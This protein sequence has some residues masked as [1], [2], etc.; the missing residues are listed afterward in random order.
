MTSAAPFLRMLILIGEP[1]S[2]LPTRSTGEESP[3]YDVRTVSTVSFYEQAAGCGCP[4]SMCAG[5]GS[6]PSKAIPNIRVA[7][8]PQDEPRGSLHA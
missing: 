4:A 5:L 6:N 1:I 2:T 3:V 8:S 7:G